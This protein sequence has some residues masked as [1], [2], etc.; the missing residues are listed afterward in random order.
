VTGATAQAM[1]AKLLTERPTRLR[2][3]RDTVPEAM[4]RA[5]EKALAKTPADRFSLA[6]DFV[7][8]LERAANIS[9]ERRVPVS[10]FTI[11]VAAVAAV[12]VAGL[13]IWVSRGRAPVAAPV[14]T[15]RDRA[16][17]TSTG[18]VRLPAI[19][20]DGKT[21]A[22]V[23]SNCTGTGCSYGI[24]LQDVGGTASKR[25]FEG[26]T[27]LYGVEWSPDRRNLIF[28][29][30][31]DG[32]FGEYVISALGG[33]PRRVSSFRAAFWAG[34]D[35]LLLASAD[36]DRKEYWVYVAGLD[37][38]R[39]DSIRVPGPGTE[40]GDLRVA[41]NSRW[42][43]VGLPR[44]GVVEWRLMDHGGKVGGHMERA[45]LNGMLQTYL[46]N[47]AIW[48][49]PGIKGTNQHM[50]V[51][52]AFDSATGRISS[53]AD[54]LYSGAFTAFSVTAD[55]GSLVVDEGTSEYDAWVLPLSDALRGQFSPARRI[56][57]STSPIR[58]VPSPDGSRAI[59]GRSAGAG[60]TMRYAVKTI[61]T[62]AETPL[63][64]PN[65]PTSIWWEMPSVIVVSERVGKQL[66][67][68]RVEASTGT[69]RDWFEVPDVEVND[70]A[71]FKDHGWVWLP[72]P[73]RNVA[74]TTDAGAKVKLYPVPAWYN[75]TLNVAASSDGKRVM[76][77]GFNAPDE[78]SIGVSVLSLE[79]GSIS[80]LL[81]VFGETVGI[82]AADD[83]GFTIRIAE[84][85]EIFSFYR[86]NDAKS[87]QKLGTIPRA[88]MNAFL[89][90]D[91][92]TLNVVTRD[93]HGD[94][95]MSKVTRH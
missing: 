39:R 32:K 65:N 94:A 60:A 61:A 34:G 82:N 43:L 53:H 26:A 19:S 85:P 10:R 40:L 30:S 20:H 25:L 67:I 12:L 50:I 89:S 3:V 28:Q 38:G 16:Q 29:A 15:L 69:V 7:A 48:F 59:I 22:Y 47:D 90:R 11:I 87:I 91:Q 63:S 84:T 79:D 46:S 35:S 9:Q 62:G 33:A 80:Q 77:G 17:I 83:G 71:A 44:K 95:W 54:T 74:V 52:M 21:L 72:T 68:G 78:D 64:L 88:A 42:F 93:E 18:R 75:S 2:V 92:R 70:F 14:V 5:V 8:T 76:F 73:G 55:G 23:V 81:T 24:A 56:E 27:A 37:G 86:S 49:A 57:H 41:P 66:R 58:L 4:E 36:R 1:I 6:G 51:R 45:A 13:A 31:I